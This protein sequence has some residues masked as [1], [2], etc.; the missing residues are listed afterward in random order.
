MNE[1]QE[2]EALPPFP[3]Q[4]EALLGVYWKA[5]YDEGTGHEP[6]VDPNETLSR[7]R[8]AVR[9]YARAAQASTKESKQ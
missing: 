8:E 6:E 5:G 4:I 2:R 1:N 9:G 3:S 7:I